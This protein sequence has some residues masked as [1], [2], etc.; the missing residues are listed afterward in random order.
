M[1]IQERSGDELAIALFFLWHA[2]V[3]CP[4]CNPHILRFNCP[5]ANEQIIRERSRDSMVDQ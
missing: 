3:A 5:S 2:I 4:P 1:E